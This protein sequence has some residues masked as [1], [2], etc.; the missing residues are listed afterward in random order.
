MYKPTNTHYGLWLIG[1]GLLLMTASAAGAQAEPA[2]PAVAPGPKAAG[3]A[4]PAPEFLV[5]APSAYGFDDTVDLLKGAIEAENLMLIHEIDAQRM[6]RMVQVTTPGMKQLLFFHPR[7]MKRIRETN[8]AGTIEPPLK[9]AVMEGPDG[10][11]MV[12]YIKP[13]YLFGRY[14]GLDPIGQELEDLVER[15][16]AVVES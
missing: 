6:L 1:A 11:V 10:K 8:P 2:S 15:I 13:S 12:R 16:V 14:A 5:T 3:Q 4:P 9:L 7:Y